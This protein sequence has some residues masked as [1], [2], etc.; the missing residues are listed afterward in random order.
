MQKK[1]PSELK[2]KNSIKCFIFEAKILIWEKL[3]YRA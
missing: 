1:F 3:T 2:V